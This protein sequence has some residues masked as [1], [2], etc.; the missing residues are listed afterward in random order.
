MADSLDT[1]SDCGDEISH[2]RLEGNNNNVTLQV[3]SSRQNTIES[4][5]KSSVQGGVG[6]SFTGP[7]ISGKAGNSSEMKSAR[8]EVDSVSVNIPIESGPT[9]TW[10]ENPDPDQDDVVSGCLTEGCDNNIADKINRGM[11]NIEELSNQIN[12]D[13]DLEEEDVAEMLDKKTTF[14][15]SN[16]SIDEIGSITESKSKGAIGRYVGKARS[17]VG[18]AVSKARSGASSAATRVRGGVS[19]TVDAVKQRFGSDDQD[20]NQNSDV[21]PPAESPEQDNTVAPPEETHAEEATLHVSPTGDTEI[22]PTFSNGAVDLA[23]ANGEAAVEG[24]TIHV[25]LSDDIPD[26]TPGDNGSVTVG[27]GD[28]AGTTMEV[29]PGAN[30]EADRSFGD[31]DIQL[32]F[33]D[34]EV[35]VSPGDDEIQMETGDDGDIQM[36]VGDESITRE[37]SNDPATERDTPPGTNQ[38]TNPASTP[39]PQSTERNGPTSGRDGAVAATGATTNGHEPTSDSDSK[40]LG[41]DTPENL[42]SWMEKTDDQSTDERVDGLD[43]T[44]EIDPDRDD[45]D[46][47]TP[48]GSGRGGRG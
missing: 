34:G 35:R 28:A 39:D 33:D 42:S 47:S 8:N 17:S 48:S 1:C 5:S 31:G 22:D 18:T 7:K 15:F 38:D 26:V 20:P 43:P 4:V 10:L 21:V 16:G 3:D 46:D 11:E 9:I 24:T 25:S 37:P 32:S 14:D 27:L 19:S 23:L 29:S 45:T 13:N 2:V 36:A 41:P 44:G 6:L 12:T 40:W 30:D